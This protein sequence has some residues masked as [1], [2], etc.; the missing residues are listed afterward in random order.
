MAEAFLLHLLSDADSFVFILGLMPLLAHFRK[1]PAYS[2]GQIRE[3][4]N[5][6]AL[7]RYHTE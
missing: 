2:S 7:P 1:V 3:Q 5:G 4:V 6:A